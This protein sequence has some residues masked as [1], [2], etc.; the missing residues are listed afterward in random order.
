VTFDGLQE[1]LLIDVVKGEQ[2]EIERQKDQLI[3][4]LS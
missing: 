4:D 1:Q 3:V 2:P